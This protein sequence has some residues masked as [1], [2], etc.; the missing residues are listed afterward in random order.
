[1]TIT[2]QDELNARHFAASY[3]TYSTRRQH[4]LKKF[5]EAAGMQENAAKL[6]L[7]TIIAGFNPPRGVSEKRRMQLFTQRTNAM[8]G[9]LINARRVAAKG[10]QHG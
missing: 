7:A 1:M 8:V 5:A 10:R 4:Y 6:F 9:G 2:Q 3:F